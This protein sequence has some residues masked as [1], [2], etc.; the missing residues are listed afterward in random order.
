M[1]SERGRSVS[2]LKP[3]ELA[4]AC[5]SHLPVCFGGGEG[6]QK[7]RPPAWLSLSLSLFPLC[8]LHLCLTKRQA[9]ILVFLRA[10]VQEP[11][12]VCSGPGQGLG[13]KAEKVHFQGVSDVD[14]RS[15]RLYPCRSVPKPPAPLKRPLHLNLKHLPC[16]ISA[17]GQA[18][19]GHSDQSG[20]HIALES[21][22][23]ELE[24]GASRIRPG[25]RLETQRSGALPGLSN[26]REIPGM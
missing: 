2:S 26:K 19:R 16:P 18:L 5:T 20:W 22:S 12:F 7:D 11:F 1:P 9:L 3:E 24:K 23:T 8:P 13:R 4:S 25:Q 17:Q 10:G 21:C 15:L 6:E 14:P